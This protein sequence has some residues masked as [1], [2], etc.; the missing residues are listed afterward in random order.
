MR[1]TGQEKGDRRPGRTVRIVL[2]AAAAALV[3]L[4][5]VP[6]AAAFEKWW[7]FQMG[8]RLGWP[9]ISFGER[10]EKAEKVEKLLH[11]SLTPEAWEGAASKV[12]SIATGD[13]RAKVEADLGLVT[14]IIGTENGG[15]E[16]VKIADGYIDAISG[17]RR[18]QFGY[19]DHRLVIRKWIVTFD[20]K[21]KVS[22]TE[23][24]P[25]GLNDALQKEPKLPDDVGN[26][27]IGTP[28][29]VDYLLAGRR[30]YS[31]ISP[32]GWERAKPKLEKL[33]PGDSRL[34]LEEASN[35]R[36]YL[37][38]LKAWPMGDGYLPM[39]SVI[40]DGTDRETMAF[41]WAEHYEPIVKARVTLTDDAIQVIRFE[42]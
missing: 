36:Y 6:P 8:F 42:P 35:F 26:G 23:V 7:S 31:F 21:G 14:H 28:F 17:P 10:H 20:G 27:P 33:R 39:S 34:A 29:D 24:F 9:P 2:G 13:D 22:G 38:H 15:T 16:T 4:G 11:D 40:E 19:L 5:Q 30:G 37:L 1:H 3:V 32:Q 18:M 41:G 12:R 25:D